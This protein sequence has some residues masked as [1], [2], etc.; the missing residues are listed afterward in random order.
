[1]SKS[2][3][4]WIHTFLLRS[5]AHLAGAIIFL[6]DEWLWGDD[7]GNNSE[8]HQEKC[9]MR[10]LP[11]VIQWIPRRGQLACFLPCPWFK[12]KVC[13]SLQEL[14]FLCQYPMTTLQ[15][16]YW[17]HICFLWQILALKI[18]WGLFYL[19][20]HW[21]KLA[22]HYRISIIPTGYV[23]WQAHTCSCNRKPVCGAK[24]GWTY[25]HHMAKSMCFSLA[26]GLNRQ[27]YCISVVQ[28]HED[29]WSILANSHL[30]LGSLKIFPCSSAGDSIKFSQRGHDILETA[31]L[32]FWLLT[33]SRS[34][35]NAEIHLENFSL[36]TCCFSDF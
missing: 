11:F 36:K 31:G 8:Q 26:T 12:D 4:L 10:P 3:H 30:D 20:P 28:H 7:S 32:T 27:P 5:T 24:R 6:G 21:Q 19:F 9:C 23:I 34:G 18:I 22:G 13:Q 25:T 29:R 1:M 35:C 17:I 2:S 16:W 33:L 15:I 14:P